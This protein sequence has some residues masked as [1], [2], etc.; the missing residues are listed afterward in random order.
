MTAAK[1]WTW[2]QDYH[3]AQDKR[4]TQYPLTPKSKWKMHQRYWKCQRQN[5]QIFGYVY[6]DTNGRNHGPVWKIHL[7]LINGICTVLLWH[8]CCGKGNSRKFYQN[9]VGKKFWIENAYSVTGK[10]GYSYLCFVDDIK[11][12]E[13]KQNICPAWEI[14]MKDVEMW[15][16][17]SFFD[18]V[19]LGCTQTECQISKDIVDNYRS[20]F[21]IQHFCWCDGK[22]TWSQS[23]RETRD[24]HHLFMVQWHG[25]SCEETRG[26]ILRTCEWNDWAVVS[27]RDAM[28][29]WPSFYRRR[30]W[31]CWRI[32]YCLLKNCSGMLILG[33]YWKTRYSVVCEQTCSCGNEIDKSLWQTF[34]AFDLVTFITQVNY[35]QYCHV[36]NTAQ[37]CRIGIISK[38]LIFQVT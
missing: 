23:S 26:K 38:I 2:Y 10:K 11:L 19:Y 13:K 16:P 27:S 1:V 7:S 28:L 25:R 24:K 30:K 5:V 34:G 21:E 18:H 22:F 37:K 31:I 29:G 3:D 20:M 15:E 32:T 35:K 17:T 12:A 6:H 36:G 33:T 4:Q 8:D 9:M 14:L